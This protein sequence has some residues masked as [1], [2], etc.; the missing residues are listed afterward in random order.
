VRAEAIAAR[1]A[2]VSAEAEQVAARFR[3]AR[4]IGGL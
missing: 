3:L 1:A 2:G 4:A